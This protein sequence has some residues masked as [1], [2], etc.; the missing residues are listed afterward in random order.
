MNKSLEIGAGV[1]AA[2]FAIRYSLARK[3]YRDDANDIFENPGHA[4]RFF[5]RKVLAREATQDFIKDTIPLAVG[6]LGIP[7]GIAECAM[8]NTG[9]GLFSLA[10]AVPHLMEAVAYKRHRKNQ[11]DNIK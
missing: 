8:G 10:V 1:W 3:M 5:V 11:V 9:F 2:S 7:L 4:N 6:V